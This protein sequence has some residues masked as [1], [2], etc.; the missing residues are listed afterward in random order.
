MT[1]EWIHN[2]D[3]RFTYYTV[4]RLRSPFHDD[5]FDLD[6]V[7]E[8]IRLRDVHKGQRTVNE[9]LWFVQKLYDV[10][11]EVNAPVILDAV[12]ALRYRPAIAKHGWAALMDLVTVHGAFTWADEPQE[13]DYIMAYDEMV[14][15][16]SEGYRDLLEACDGDYFVV[17]ALLEWI[18]REGP[19]PWLCKGGPR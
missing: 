1:D 3:P 16:A 13:D 14:G 12:T 15:M 9:A 19:F 11:R 4:P 18:D 10:I 7:H 2:R 8:H 6:A 17:Y 5:D